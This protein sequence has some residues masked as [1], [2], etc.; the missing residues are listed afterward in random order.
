[1]LSWLQLNPAMSLPPLNAFQNVNA[2][3]AAFDTWAQPWLFQSTVAAILAEPDRPAFERIW[4]TACDAQY[5]KDADLALAS[6]RA[7]QALRMQFPGLSREALSA[8]VRAAAYQ[9]R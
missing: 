2:A 7:E 3:I 1:M 6:L 8:V 5:W 9:W 4:A